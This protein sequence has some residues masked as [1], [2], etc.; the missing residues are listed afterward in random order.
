VTHLVFQGVFVRRFNLK[1]I[2]INQEFCLTRH[3][4]Y[5]TQPD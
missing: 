4:L 1:V 2:T 3:Q 5:N